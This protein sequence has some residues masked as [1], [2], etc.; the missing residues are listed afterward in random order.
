MQHEETQYPDF[1]RVF[2]VHTQSYSMHGTM[3]DP[4]L[5]EFLVARLLIASFKKRFFIGYTTTL[6]EVFA[7][8]SLVAETGAYIALV[9]DATKADLMSI[10]R[11]RSVL[12]ASTGQT[13]R[14]LWQYYSNIVDLRFRDYFSHHGH[15]P[16]NLRVME[17]FD[18][19]GDNED[20]S[21]SLDKK[22]TWDQLEKELLPGIVAGSFVSFN[23]GIL[24]AVNHPDLCEGIVNHFKAQTPLMKLCSIWASTWRPQMMRLFEDILLERHVM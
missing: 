16:H 8:V 6:R 13:E 3:N 21:K 20:I 12:T 1:E 10:C 15:Y 17:D 7:A 2:A 24:T 9:T 11:P 18:L 22:M 23:A 4:Y 5:P 19:F 14:V